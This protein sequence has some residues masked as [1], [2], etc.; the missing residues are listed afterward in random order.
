MS[1]AVFGLI[2]V[3]IGVI[4]GFAGNYILQGQTRKWQ[5]EDERR[6]AKQ[7]PLKQHREKVED[8]MSVAAKCFGRDVP[9]EIA[10]EHFGNLFLAVYH[11]C[12]KHMLTENEFLE[13]RDELREAQANPGAILKIGTK[14]C[15]WID[16]AIDATYQEDAQK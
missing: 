8:M 4:L 3:C 12:Q 6:K 10:I 14:V 2:G 15:A 11:L 16:E 1:N 9:I 7:E 5:I 13:F